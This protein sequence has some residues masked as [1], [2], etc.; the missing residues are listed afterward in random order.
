MAALRVMTWNV[1]NL[2]LHGEKDG[3]KTQAAFDAKVRSLAAVIDDQKP[4]VLALQEIGS[5]GAFGALRSALSHEMPHAAVGEPDRRRIRVAF[6]STRPLRSIH[7]LKAF[8]GGLKPVQVK[9]SALDHPDTPGDESAI[10]E[11]GRGALEV[12][13]SVGGWDVTILN[14]HLKS[15]LI[16]Y[17]DN[18]GS[19]FEPRN[20]GE[21]CRYSAYALFR[22]TGEAVTVRERLN[23]L[24]A[25]PERPDAPKVGRGER[26]PVI[27]C[28]DLNDEPNAAT[29]Q[30][31]QGPPGS[32][33][34]T[35]GFQQDDAGDAYRMWNLAPLLGT[36]DGEP[37]YSRRY[38]GRGELIDHIFASKLL[39]NR[40]N[41]PICHTV[42]SPDPLPSME[43]APDARKNDTGSDHAAIVATF[44]L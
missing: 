15:K 42:R 5:D 3:P 13:I 32:E 34:G 30:I 36:V 19:R 20:E 8:P 21:R 38:R 6:L 22:R 1:Q 28:G 2:F 24:L 31:I 25:D 43:D 33:F 9:D 37:A 26:T 40:R 27:F 23:A 7:R 29:T 4:H 11:M 12:T 10:N 41:K 39:I 16:Q 18:G 17:P 35:A 44:D 14:A